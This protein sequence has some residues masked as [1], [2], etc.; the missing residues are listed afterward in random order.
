MI[1]RFHRT[2]KTALKARPTGP[3]WVEELP[4]VLLGFR[5]T[6][7]E[8]LGYSSAELVYGEPLTIPGE[9]VSPKSAKSV[10]DLLLN[11]KLNITLYAPRT[12]SH[13]TPAVPYLSLSLST[14][15]H[16]YV[17]R[18]GSKD[19]LQRPYSGRTQF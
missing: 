16:V 18:N 7:K 5:I 10:D 4:W 15:K 19:P 3:N 1:K 14:A 17:Q 11:F 6:P 2:L 13:H 9:L 12:A 8:D